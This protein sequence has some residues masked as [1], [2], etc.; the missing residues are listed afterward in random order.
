[1]TVGIER[2]AA[3]VPQYALRLDDLAVAR[4]LPAER[5]RQAFGVREMS[6]PAPC[7]DAVTLAATAGARVLRAANASPRS[8][9]MLIV[10]TG[11]GVDHTKPVA[12]FVQELLAIG[13]TSRV[14]DVKHGAYAGTAG[15]MAAADWVRAGGARDR[16]ALVIAADTVRH[17]IGSAD[18]PIQG[19]G[20]VA[21]LIEP[22]PRAIV[23]SDDSGIH[24]APAHDVWRP[25]GSRELIVDAGASVARYLEALEHAFGAFRAHERPPLEPDEGLSD[26]LAH[27]LYHAAFPSMAALAHRRLVE[28]D[29]KASPARWA[30]VAERLDAEAARSFGELA[31]QGVEIGG[32]VGHTH[33]ATVY[34]GLAALL[35]AEGRKLG[36]RRIG[37]FSYG[38]GSCSEFFTGFVPA[39][40][41]NVADAGIAAMLSGRSMIDVATYE[42]LHR[43]AEQGGE[44]PAGFA[45][46][47]V[48]QGV[49]D[50]RRRYAALSR[51][52]A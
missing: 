43:A 14:F 40:V 41:A 33:T 5:F 24:S 22:Q 12:S 31:A 11:S 13:S 2:F 35:E 46:E 6:I 23:L 8:V 50:G 29:W 47:F 37:V 10:A 17:G 27:I 20:A 7:E 36:G 39:G 4:G 30:R 32:R 51:P 26:R 48:Y 38:G 42:R 19:A 25:L 34:L 45:G 28:I 21:M 44:P 52:A 1:M 3:Y 18:E 15:V 16:R 9:G 49:T